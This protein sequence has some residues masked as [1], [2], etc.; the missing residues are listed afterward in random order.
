MK[1]VMS[2]AIAGVAVFA[3]S[4]CGGDGSGGGGGMDTHYLT[5]VHGVGIGNVPYDCSVGGAGTTG[6]DG[7]Y[8]FES[9]GDN[10]TFTFDQHAT[11]EPLYIKRSEFGAGVSGLR[12]RCTYNTG[13]SDTPYQGWTDGSGHIKHVWNDG[14]PVRDKCTLEY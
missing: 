1:R 5:N 2:I 11:D 7:A 14:G 13:S 8:G 9:G 6:A 12:Y 4:G 10:C 3:L